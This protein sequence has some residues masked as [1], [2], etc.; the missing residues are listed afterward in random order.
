MRVRSS[1]ESLNA[2]RR[3]IAFLERSR[4]MD[5]WWRDFHTLAGPSDEWVTAYVAYALADLPRGRDF[6]IAAWRLLVPRS[7]SGGFGYAAHVPPDCDT[8]AW[9]CR[10]AER[11]GTTDTSVYRH[12]VRFLRSAITA[13][14][15]IPTYGKE[16]PI[17]KFTGLD[18]AVSFEGWTSAHPCV[19]ANVACVAG[20]RREFRS[21]LN[22]VRNPSGTWEGY[23]W[24]SPSF[25]TMLACEALGEQCVDWRVDHRSA[26]DLA[27]ALTVGV[28]VREEL[29]HQQ[30]PDG[31]W[32]SSAHLRVPAPFVRNSQAGPARRTA[33]HNRIFTTATAIRAL[34]V[35]SR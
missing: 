17:R 5:G 29:L 14:G 24:P 3:G 10:L 13:D 28:P 32:P 21:Y 30:L 12:A 33:D 31:S 25:P 4:Q 8:T 1:N 15:G 6:S 35:A 23:W 18:R 7:R 34:H 16:R 19:T 9:V 20:L 11:L 2:I 26:F 22:N 27:C